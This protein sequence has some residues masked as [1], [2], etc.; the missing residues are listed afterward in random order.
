MEFWGARELGYF[1][2]FLRA[3]VNH[4]LK[5]VPTKIGRVDPHYTPIGR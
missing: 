3:P 5:P 1:P 4:P 2:Q